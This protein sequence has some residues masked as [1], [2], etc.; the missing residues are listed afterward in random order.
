MR[1][2]PKPE[3]TPVLDPETMV[4]CTESF[5]PGAIARQIEKGQWLPLASPNVQA[6][7]ELFAVPLQALANSHKQM[8]QAK[9]G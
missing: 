5:R 8:D 7:P 1:R 9:Q 6:F 4:I 3:P 2:H